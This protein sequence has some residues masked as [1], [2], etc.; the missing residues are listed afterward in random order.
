MNTC[1]LVVFPR[2]ATTPC[3]ASAPRP[4]MRGHRMQ[5]TLATG[6]RVHVRI[7]APVIVEVAIRVRLIVTLHIGTVVRVVRSDIVVSLRVCRD[8]GRQQHKC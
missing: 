1:L 7:C 3:V 4:G 5:S 6:E 2:T 8:H